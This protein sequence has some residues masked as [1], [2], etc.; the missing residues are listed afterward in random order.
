M[1]LAVAGKAH[2]Q[3]VQSSQEDK[4]KRHR[5]CDGSDGHSLRTAHFVSKCT[6]ITK[7][8]R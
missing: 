7:D 3:Y 8:L 2:P 1:T 5:Q 4:T 6:V